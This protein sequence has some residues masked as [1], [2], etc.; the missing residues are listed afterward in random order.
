MLWPRLEE[1]VIGAIIGVAS[2]W[3]VLPVRSTPVL[4]RRI[5]DALAVLADALDPATPA[6][7]S[8]DFVAAIASVEQIAP[9]FR[10]SRPLMR[11]FNAIQ[12]MDWIDAL[13]A[14]RTPAVALID[15]SETPVT[16]RRAVGAARKSVREPAELQQALRELCRSLQDGPAD[17]DQA[18]D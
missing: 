12:P 13:V 18:S 14:C 4:R 3:F 2:A 9:A 10:A 1:I 5:A 6:R 7:G 15:L 17:T 11:H 16:V 8:D